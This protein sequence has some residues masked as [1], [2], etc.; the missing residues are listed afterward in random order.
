MKEVSEYGPHF[1]ECLNP[2][3]C[4]G[5]HLVFKNTPGKL[6][7]TLCQTTRSWWDIDPEISFTHPLSTSTV[8]R[9]CSLPFP[10]LYSSSYTPKIPF[11]CQMVRSPNYSLY[12]A[13][14]KSNSN[15]QPWCN[16]LT[17][18]HVWG[19]TYK[20]TGRKPWPNLPGLDFRFILFPIL[21]VK[22]FSGFK[23]KWKM[24]FCFWT[25]NQSPFLILTITI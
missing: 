23:L 5:N 1:S 13:D 9:L 12:T 14:D 24:I 15:S 16:W 21:I 7:L 10:L 4:I 18:W 22:V 6:N 3:T 20:G 2:R 17:E 8:S 11:P 25:W 19:R